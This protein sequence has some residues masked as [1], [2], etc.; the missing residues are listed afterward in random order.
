MSVNF[1]EGEVRQIDFC[2]CIISSP[3]SHLGLILVRNYATYPTIGWADPSSLQTYIAFGWP[4]TTFPVTFNSRNL[5]F[6]TRHW[7]RIADVI[8]VSDR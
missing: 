2:N 5:A 4:T 8:C 6:E 3:W 7:K 1:V